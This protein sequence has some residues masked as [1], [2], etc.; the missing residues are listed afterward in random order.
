MSWCTQRGGLVP[1]PD[2]KANEFE[3]V[4]DAVDFLATQL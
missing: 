3:T 4:K 1:I 2:E